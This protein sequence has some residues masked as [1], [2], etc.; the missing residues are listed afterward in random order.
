MVKHLITTLIFLFIFSFTISAQNVTYP[1]SVRVYDIPEIT[2][3]E[4][5]N[6]TEIRSTSP[7]QIISANEI[8]RLNA[9]QLSDAVKHF[10]GVTVK[11]YGGIG[12]VKTIST[13][14]LGANHTAITY[15]G[16]PVSDL[17]TGQI[18]IGRFSLDNVDRISLH[19]GQSDNIF[20]P[21]RTF[22]SASV[23]NIRTLPPVFDGKKL[24]GKVSFKTGSFGLINPQ[25]NLS[26]KFSPIFCGTFSGEY[27]KSKGDYPFT[28]KYGNSNED[29][30]TTEK[31]KNTDVEN[32]RLEG[33]MYANFT[34]KENAYL[35]VYYYQTE[36]GLPGSIIYYNPDQNLNQRTWDKTFFT[37]GN[38]QKEFS[39]Y[40]VFQVN[41]KYNR[42]WMRYLD[43]DYLGS[44]GKDE[45]HYSQKEYYISSSLLYRAFENLSFSFSAD[46]SIN[47]M[48]ADFEDFAYPV[49][50]SLLSV[51]AAKYVTNNFLATA[52]VLNT[53]VTESVRE[54]DVAENHS[55]FSPYISLSYKPFESQDLRFR[56]FYKNIFRLP[57]FNDL[58]YNKI[59]NVTLKPESTNQYNAGITYATNIN[60][61]IPFISATLDFYH[62]DISNKIVA[63]PRKDIF[64]WSMLNYGKVSVNGLDLSADATIRFEKNISLSLGGNYTYQRALNTTNPSDPG[65]YKHQ[66]PYT[67]RICGSGKAGIET[68]WVNVFYSLIWSGHRYTITQNYAE[69][70]LPGYT[71][72]S[73]SASRDFNFQPGKLAVNF[74]L[75]NLSGKN[76]QV[77]KGY[78][79]PGRSFRCS[80]SWRF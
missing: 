28:Y 61:A 2:V 63:L 43:S 21:A 27:L 75:L 35:K 73:I 22:A 66:I 41:A 78:P 36:R 48:E 14:S 71:D 20:Q 30:S 29:I 74:E 44:T 13:R 60:N 70:R 9:L 59:G 37:Q 50:Y 46:G 25:L 38:Y 19:N 39:R 11:D 6:N 79:M 8:I 34:E 42:T 32:L 23:L 7:L 58:Y 54:G 77:V 56:V 15:D 68:P 64:L 16:I 76:Y 72:H 3:T 31:R 17:Q 5:Y 40:L 80:V 24:I 49:R 69:N 12:G 53:L 67:P 4:K 45:N 52:S 51:V 55:R 65:T 26:A 10:S 18:D 62:N 33:A 57:T 47:D 1:D